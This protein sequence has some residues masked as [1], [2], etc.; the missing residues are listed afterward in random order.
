MPWLRMDLFL[1]KF[2]NLLVLTFVH[3]LL[4][5]FLEKAWNFNIK[6]LTKLYRHTLNDVRKKT[7]RIK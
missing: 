6:F 7:F 1:S 4:K 5:Y 3:P 2:K